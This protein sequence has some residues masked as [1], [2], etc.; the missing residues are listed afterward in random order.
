MLAGKLGQV[1]RGEMVSVF[2]HY[3]FNSIELVAGPG[4][5]Q[6]EQWNTTE[7]WEHRPYTTLSETIQVLAALHGKDLG[8]LADFAEGTEFRNCLAYRNWHSARE[9]GGFF[10]P[11]RSMTETTIVSQEAW[12]AMKQRMAGDG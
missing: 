3:W 11:D 12:E 2:A 5:E 1:V 7:L 9:P 4:N 6:K 10:N 8:R